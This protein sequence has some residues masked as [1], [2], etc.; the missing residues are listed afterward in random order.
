MK[1]NVLLTVNEQVITVNQAVGYLQSSGKLEVFLEAILKQHILEQE[2][3]SRLELAIDPQ[4]FEQAIAHFRSEQQLVDPDRFQ[5]WLGQQGLDEPAFHQQIARQIQL[6]QLV[7]QIT[8][9]KLQ[10]VFIDRKLHLDRVVLSHIVVADLE[11]AE[12]LKAQLEEEGVS[13]ERLAQ[14]Y[15]TATDR[16][17][18]G[19]IGA[20][21]KGQMSHALRA[22]IDTAKPG[23]I[24]GPIQIEAEW[25]LFRVEQFLPATLAD[26]R[27]QHLLQQEIFEE[28][29]TE[30]LRKQQ[31]YLQLAQTPDAAHAA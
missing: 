11:L 2:L 24:V 1:S 8:E 29:L 18:N 30:K 13:F 10:E 22:L 26:Q 19:M 27:I 12:E 3:Q 7:S 25:H 28:W 20:I 15:S 9:P 4:V 21:S 6:N 31:V 5:A 23:D 17:V 14:E 16:L